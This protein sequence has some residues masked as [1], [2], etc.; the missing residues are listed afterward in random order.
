MYKGVI[1]FDYLICCIDR[2]ETINETLSLDC[3]AQELSVDME[4]RSKSEAKGCSKRYLFC[5]S[6]RVEDSKA[7]RAESTT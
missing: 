1:F 6:E 4:R 5:V 2:G 7:T 3:L